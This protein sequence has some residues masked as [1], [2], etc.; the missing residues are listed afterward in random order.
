VAPWIVI[1]WLDVLAS[2]VR[3]AGV[4]GL[5]AFSAVFLALPLAMLPTLQMYIAAGAIYGVWWGAVLTTIL[6]VVAVAATHLLVRTRLRHWVERRLQRHPKLR[7]VDRG[8]GEHAF[9]VALLL[10]ISPAPFGA[11]NYALES[12]RLSLSRNLV[13]TAVGMLPTNV[14]YAYAGA[15]LHGDTG[16]TWHRIALFVGIAAGVG[17]LALIAWATRRAL[18]A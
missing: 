16:S 10:R 7:A 6:S 1:D 12:T 14:L 17:A 13:T 3:D 11:L 15:L 8:I 5:A 4:L 9:W 2:W 18:K